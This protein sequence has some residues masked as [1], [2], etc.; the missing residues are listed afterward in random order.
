VSRLLATLSE[1]TGIW[2][3]IECNL[4]LADE[5]KAC[6]TSDIPLAILFQ[7]S[8]QETDVMIVSSNKNHVKNS[9]AS[10]DPRFLMISPFNMGGPL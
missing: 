7:I 10:R 3:H 8:H 6:K 4:A 1:K 5:S 2:I 9:V